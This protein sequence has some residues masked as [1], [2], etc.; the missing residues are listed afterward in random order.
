MSHIGNPSAFRFRFQRRRGRAALRSRV[1]S[2]AAPRSLSSGS[3]VIRIGGG[4]GAGAAYGSIP[5]GGATTIGNPATG[6][7]TALWGLFRFD[8][9]QD[10]FGI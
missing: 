9:T 6:T 2:I 10:L 8:S 3:Q 1:E 5:A 4:N 7:R